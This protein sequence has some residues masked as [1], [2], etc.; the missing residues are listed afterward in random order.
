MY[1]IAGGV[2][3]GWAM[4]A[5]DSANVFGTGVASGAVRFRTATILTAVFALIGALMEG[6]RCMGTLNSLTRL[7]GQAM[8]ALIATLSAGLT[9]IVLTALSLPA[10]TSQAVVGALIGIGL[11]NQSANFRPLI[12]VVVCWVATPVAG[13]V[14]AYIL[15]I[16]VGKIMH[17]LV[18]G[19]RRFDLVLRWSILGAGCYA[20]YALGANN[21]ANATGPFVGA[22]LIDPFFGSLIAG[23]SIGFGALTFS[24]AVMTTVG[25]R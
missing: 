15:Y 20:A 3:L 21:A 23:L 7:E 6:P 19:V 22:G 11:W 2:V 9:V 5:N 8:L 12:K 17:R 1:H 16:A 24:R 14:L 4:G 18:K 10:S 25:T 13:A